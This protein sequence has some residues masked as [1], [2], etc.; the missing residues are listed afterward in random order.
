[1][2]YIIILFVLLFSCKTENKSKKQSTLLANKNKIEKLDSI[3]IYEVND[4]LNFK[5]DKV[6]LMFI[7]KKNGCWKNIEIKDL[8]HNS[9]KRI[10]TPL[11]I[12]FEKNAI[13]DFSPNQKFL[14]L[15]A[16]ERGILLDGNLEQNVE[17]YNCIFLDIENLLLSKKYT[18]MFCSGEWQE[19]DKWVIDDYEYKQAKDLF[20]F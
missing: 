8:V 12:C 10:K 2:K 17:K 16:L 13:T 5:L 19:S 11:N 20:I 3:K 6:L 4:T 18:G 7:N 1:M 9:I 14:Q 15:H